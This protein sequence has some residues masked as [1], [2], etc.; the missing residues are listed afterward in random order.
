[1]SGR[2]EESVPS[3]E[4]TAAVNAVS[5]LPAD[6]LRLQEIFSQESSKP[7]EASECCEALAL[8]RDKS[9]L[10]SGRRVSLAKALN[11]GVFDVLMTPFEPDEVLRIAF[12][13]WSR[14][15]AALLLAPLERRKQRVMENVRS[16]GL[17]ER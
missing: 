14:R 8:S 17:T 7:H 1:M 16:F 5:A 13:A 6:G 2:A 12:A 9:V 10:S 11:L 15:G 4:S 3:P